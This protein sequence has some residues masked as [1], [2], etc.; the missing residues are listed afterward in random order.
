MLRNYLKIAWRNLLRH[1]L[2]SLLNVAGL[3]VGMAAGLVIFLI[4]RYELSFDREV[5]GGE[6]V[7][8]LVSDFKFGDEDYHNPGV[9]APIP[10]GVRQGVPGSEAVAAFHTG[11]FP[12][13]E[14]PRP[15]TPPARF[16]APKDEHGWMAY[17][18]AAFFDLLPRTWLV[19]TPA[20]SLAEPG[21]VVLTER[22]A[23]QYFGEAGPA[24]V[25]RRL[26]GQEFSD[27][28]QLT[29]SGVVSDL[30][31]PS[32]FDFD[33]F[34]SLATLTSSQKRS[35][36]RRFDQW[37]GTNSSSQ[38]LVRLAPGTDPQRFA[39]Q[40]T[41]LVESH[42]KRDASRGERWLR[43]QP[44]AD[45]HFNAD[46]AQGRPI[47]HRPT[48]LVL[49]VVGVFL[50][51]L[52][53]INFINLATA[54]STQRAREIGV[55]KTL[56]STQP[57]LI[58][59]FLGETLLLTSAAT[60]LAL[61]LARGAL[62][63][64]GDI[65]PRGV[66]LDWSRPSLYGFLVGVALLTAL[67]A[68]LYPGVLVARLAPVKALRTLAGRPAGSVSLRRV[69][70]V[71]QF[72]VAQ[73]F[74]VGA[75]LVG[76]QLRYLLETDLGFQREAIVTFDTPSRLVFNDS[77]DSRFALADRFRR[78]AGVDG[79]SMANQTPIYEGYSTSVMEYAGKRG[80]ISVNVYRKDAD[81][82][83]LNLYG[84]RLVAGRNLLPSDTTREF[85]INET[86]AR[87]LGFP[88]PAEAVGQVLG[89]SG[90][91]MPIVGVVQ[92]FH[93]RSLHTAIQPTVLL[94]AKDVLYTFH[95]R[96]RRGNAAASAQTLGQLKTLWDQAY[97]D[98]PFEARFFDETVASLY[99]KERNLSK[100]VSLATGIAVFISCLG[101]FGLVTFTAERRT[102]EIGIRKVLGASV[103]S[104]VA[105][106]SKE[107]IRLVLIAIAVASPIAWYTMNRWLQDFAY[108]IEI[109]WWLFAL[110]GLLTVLI[111]FLTIS[112]QSV[113]AA[114]MNPVKSLRNE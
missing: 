48:L 30:D 61:G 54:Q 20:L 36:N 84:L 68:G 103:A 22:Q 14:V 12:V 100:L 104:L 25:G 35:E 62:R 77:T 46:Y 39:E 113:R 33:L 17:T 74:I 55:R 66:T 97:P 32:D 87:Q 102:K 40:A 42:V 90:Q 23:R 28:L 79:V 82:A 94:A 38:C 111:A 83:Y 45:V 93:H 109:E 47:A 27:T 49:G 69:L 6:R 24:L 2:T 10:A 80:T 9:S 50:L 18:D 110:A 75:L 89:Y 51:L 19:G 91:R 16:P 37:D 44:L 7:Y 53:C 114:L 26:I 96:L 59:Q 60:L 67:L 13:V 57:Q 71:G 41:R 76:Q 29:V 101:L 99:E 72:V 3:S 106:L 4:V 95:V 64:L 92:D 65:I 63:Y 107:F 78:V 70:I 108:K 52:A 5:P 43:L 81:T 105:L 31:A 73:V 85:V 15:G 58:G 112:Y 34:I 86:F 88:R 1:R 98:E 56:G 8:R 11:G 21:Q